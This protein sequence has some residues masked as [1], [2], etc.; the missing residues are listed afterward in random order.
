MCRDT[1]GA[2]LPKTT[3]RNLWREAQSAATCGLR[4]V[5]CE[6]GD[7][8]H[9]SRAIR[10]SRVERAFA[11]ISPF[12]LVPTGLALR[13]GGSPRLLP[14][15]AGGAEAKR[16]KAVRSVT[17][18]VRRKRR[19]CSAARVVRP[20]C[21]P[22]IAYRLRSIAIT[23]FNLRARTRGLPTLVISV[24][25]VIERDGVRHGECVPDASATL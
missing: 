4:A 23:L 16:R 3:K 12:F 14:S 11:S 21:A 18:R 7:L 9:A 13:L 2:V 20:A 5:C 6:K 17:K 10:R 19:A 8:R 1:P 25:R 15:R 24:V 22:R